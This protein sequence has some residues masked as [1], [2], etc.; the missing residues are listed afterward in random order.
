[1]NKLNIL[2]LFLIG[3]FALLNCN[4]TSKKNDDKVVQN[5]ALSNIDNNFE[6]FKTKFKPIALDKLKELGVEFNNYLVIYDTTLEVSKAY[7]ESY[8][9]NMS[10]KYM[11]YGFKTELPNKSI[12][13]TFLNHYGNDNFNEGEE[14]DT[15]FFVSYIFNESGKFQSR[16]RIF[17]S[18]L[19]AQM[20]SYNMV[21]KFEYENDRLIITNFEYSVGKSPSEIGPIPG[22]DSIYLAN[23]TTTKYYLDFTTNKII[24]I[25]KMKSKAKVVYVIQSPCY[26]KPIE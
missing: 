2:G 22:S 14:I 9:K 4:Q 11:W 17:G 8:L 10:T 18:D 7:K 12:M 16:F 5:E 6:I 19:S 25:N 20:P 15:S 21:S 23:M 1:M 3:L 26:L 24:P 13:L